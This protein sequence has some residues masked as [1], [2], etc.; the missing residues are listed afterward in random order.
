MVAWG[1][2]TSAVGLPFTVGPARLGS[3]GIWKR[4]C[5][6]LKKGR[7]PLTVLGTRR[8]CGCPANGAGRLGD[9]NSV[10]RGIFKVSRGTK[11]A[12]TST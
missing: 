4:A 8:I 12:M 6:G 10:L 3:L 7:A 5:V 11:V 1:T 2:T 9:E